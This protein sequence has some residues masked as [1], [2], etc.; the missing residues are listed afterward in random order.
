M[1]ELPEGADEC[2][3]RVVPSFSSKIVRIIALVRSR[4]LQVRGR[5][6]L[7]SICRK[8]ECFYQ[9]ITILVDR[10]SIFV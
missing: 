9:T 5:N 8:M 3:A 7:T 4:I 1:E 6:S 2:I 10:M